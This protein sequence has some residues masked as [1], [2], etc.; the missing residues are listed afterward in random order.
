MNNEVELKAILRDPKTILKTLLERVGHSVSTRRMI[1]TYYNKLDET[2][3]RQDWHLRI[4]VIQGHA[5]GRLEFHLPQGDIHA[6]EYELNISDVETMDDILQ[7]LGYKPAVIVDKTRETW[8]LDDFT[9]ALDHIDHL[10]DFIEVELM[11]VE[12]ELG[13]ARITTFLGDIGIPPEDHRVD[14]HYYTMVPP[15][16]T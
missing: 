5:D 14:L 2:T 10:G 1:D 8:K 15:V 12:V 6:Q 7:H 3:Y 11:N 4:R 16:T 9:I 13:R